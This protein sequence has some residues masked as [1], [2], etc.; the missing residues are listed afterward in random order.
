MRKLKL[1]KLQYKVHAGNGPPILLVH[2]LL[3]SP[4]QW[5]LNIGELSQVATPVTV[6]L[7][8]HADS[9][10]PLDASSYAPENYIQQFEAI[11][12]E[13]RVDK[14]FVCGYSFGASLTMKYSLDFSSKVLGHIFTNSMSGFSDIG[15]QDMDPNTI[16]KKYDDGGLEAVERIP[17]HPKHAK[18]IPAE[19][20]QALLIDSKRMN[21]A[22]IGRSLAYSMPH[23]SSADRIGENTRPSLLV[24]G[25]KE[26]RFLDIRNY[27]AANMPHLEIVDLQAGHAVNMEQ[28]EAFND[29]VVKFVTKQLVS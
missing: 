29:A 13:L 12:E 5:L 25:A 19:V 24:H 2:G 27:L 6:S 10:A 9:P 3:S 1:N 16:V 11:R 20:A 8:G 7:Y 15:E 4:A 26:K 14:W 28:A 17:V 23:S 21:A 22:G 18:R